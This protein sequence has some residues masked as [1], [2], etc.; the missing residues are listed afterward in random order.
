MMRKTMGVLLAAALLMAA[1]PG[2]PAQAADGAKGRV[3]VEA[4]SFKDLGGWGLDQQSMDQMGSPY[5][6]A[7]GL[8]EP[9][10]DAVTKVNFGAGGA[11]HLWVRTKDWVA[12]WKAPGAPGRFQVVING[13]AVPV[14]FGTE[15]AAWHW[16]DGGTVEVPSG[17]ATLALHDLTGFEGRC[18]ALLFCADAKFTPPNGLKELG[19]WRM[20][21]LGLSETP[22]DGG[23]YD[24]VVVGGGIAGMCAALSA[25]RLGLNVAMIHDRPVFGGNNSSEVRVWLNGNTNMQ[26]FPHIGDIVKEMEPKRRAHAG[27]DNTADI[28]EDDKRDALMRGE[29]NLK[30]FLECH[31]NAVEALQ[32]RIKAVTAQNI[33]TGEKIRIS[34]RFFADCTGDGEVGTMAGADYDI[35]MK[36]HMGPT[37]VWNVVDTGK[38]AAFPRCPWAIDLSDK[39]FPGRAKNTAQFVKKG[40]SPLTSLGQWFWETGFDWDPIQDIEK[41]RDYNLRAMYGA[42]DALKNVDQLYPNHK[43]NW[44]AYVA[45]KRESVRL[46]G[47]VVLTVEDFLQSKPYEDGCYP[48]TWSIDLHYPEKKY[49]KGF[50]GNAFISYAT[51]NR[52]YK[53]PYWAPYRTL[54]SRNV[55]NLFMAGRDI[56]VTHDALGPVRVMRT[57]GMMGEVVGMAASLC[58]KAETT[59]RGVYQEHLAALKALMEKGTGKP[60]S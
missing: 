19:A 32:K 13:K 50:E 24:L 33:R 6:I 47:D 23:S 2:R 31:V 53:I 56:S 10:K 41:M 44:A 59:P 35:T 3:L 55:E 26:P 42:W 54:Y 8:G 14:T 36:Q 28:Y 43:I 48:C 21:E 51:T 11:M 25:A 1:L 38:P 45:G 15:G 30:L 20:K 34:G 57:C 40:V 7:H 49:D 4:E 39:P 27:P 22:S 37:N 29:K 16:Q 60:K 58:V 9:V 17:E 46:M 5:L 12:Q 18:D 52:K